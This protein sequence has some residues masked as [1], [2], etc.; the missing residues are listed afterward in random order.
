MCQG[1][2]LSTEVLHSNHEGSATVFIQIAPVCPKHL[3]TLATVLTEASG[4]P[5][6]D[7]DSQIYPSYSSRYKPMT[8]GTFYDTLYDTHVQTDGLA[9]YGQKFPGPEAIMPHLQPILRSIISIENA[10]QLHKNT[11]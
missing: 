11:E 1:E 6:A 3:I 7:A 5:R 9:F 2:I 8:P 4:Y 10:F